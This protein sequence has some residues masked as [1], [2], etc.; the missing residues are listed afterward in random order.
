MEIHRSRLD[1][2]MGRRADAEKEGLLAEP[3]GLPPARV[4]DR[5]AA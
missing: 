5:I 3:S 1:E 2:H 4:I